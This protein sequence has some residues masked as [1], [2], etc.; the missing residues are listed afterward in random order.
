MISN[1][2]SGQIQNGTLRNGEKLPSIRSLAHQFNVSIATAQR[3]I[4]HLERLGMMRSVRRSGCF[5]VAPQ[6][7]P[8]EYDFTGVS[9]RV[10][11]LV[12]SMLADAAR[13]DMQTL[14]SAVLGHNLAPN[15]LL[16]R[17]VS[18]I[19]RTTEAIASFSPPPGDLD[20]RK[21]IAG[22]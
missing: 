17:C 14:G 10:N 1:W 15:G 8:T 11:N 16:K 18:A 9:V 7:C 20:L 5:V 4:N 21:Q 6:T 12:A 3:A 22:K 13:P 2:L 19:A